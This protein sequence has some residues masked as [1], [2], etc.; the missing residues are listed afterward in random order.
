MKKATKPNQT[1]W[2]TAGIILFVGLLLI[3]ML[4]AQQ[5]FSH[6]IKQITI[7]VSSGPV[8]PEFQQ[9]SILNITPTS[10]TTTVTK[11]QPQTSETKS[12][13]MDSEVFNK[14]QASTGSYG[15]IDKII[16][17]NDASSL[18]G[19]KEVTISIELQNG[20]V[21][22]TKMTPRLYNDMEPYFEEIG[23]LVPAIDQV[24]PSR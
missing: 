15:V 24:L 1:I 13:P 22:S 14:V 8:S 3:V 7:M 10:C 4:I 16:A 5:S 12:C 21:F 19:G 2:L 11:V 9:T 23:L 20:T 6:K 17:N 18:M